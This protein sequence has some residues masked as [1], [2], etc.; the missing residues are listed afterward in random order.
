LSKASTVAGVRPRAQWPVLQRG[1]EFFSN[2][3]DKNSS[4]F[5]ANKN[6]ACTNDS[7]Y[8]R[9]LEGVIA[10]VLLSEDPGCPCL[11]LVA[12]PKRVVTLVHGCGYL[13]VILMMMS[14]VSRGEKHNT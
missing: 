10:S 8:V 12:T 4:V 5:T 3:L 7:D 13:E 9:F 6:V 2:H 14:V 11:C 1:Y